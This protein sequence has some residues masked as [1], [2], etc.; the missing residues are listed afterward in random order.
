MPKLTSDEYVAC[1][2]T[3][4]PNCGSDQING[5]SVDIEGGGCSQECWCSDCHARWW[6]AYQLMSYENLELDVVDPE[7]S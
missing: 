2:G 3:K 6:D 7:E 5:G 4:C 1:R